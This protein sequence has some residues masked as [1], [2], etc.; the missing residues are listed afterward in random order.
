MADYELLRENNDGLFAR[1]GEQL[2]DDRDAADERVLE[3]MR[4]TGIR[5]G[6]FVS[7]RARR[8][9]ATTTEA[10]KPASKAKPAAD[11]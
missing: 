8:T 11:G 7:E 5:H 4:E 9:K 10:E 2:G 1:V 6:Y 3:L